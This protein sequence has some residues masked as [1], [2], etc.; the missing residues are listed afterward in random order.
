MIH[1]SPLALLT[2]SK[3]VPLLTGTNSSELTALALY[4]SVDQ[5]EPLDV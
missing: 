3:M 5:G 2:A 4:P 1:T